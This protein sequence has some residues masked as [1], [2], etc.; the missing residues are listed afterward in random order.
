MSSKVFYSKYRPKQLAQ[1]V[2]QEHITGLLE[3]QFKACFF[4]HAYLLCGRYGCGKTTVARIIAKVMNCM[5]RAEGE[6]ATCG[7]CPSCIGIMNGTSTDVRELDGG[8]R[9]HKED[10]CEIVKASAYSPVHAKYRIFII[11]EFQE[12]SPHARTALLTE[13]EEPPETSVF[14]LT[15]TDYSKVPPQLASRCQRFFF[16]PVTEDRIATYLL[17][18]CEHRGVECDKEALRLIARISDGSLRTALCE[19]QSMEIAGGGAVKTADCTKYLGLMGR[20]VIYDLFAATGAKDAGQALNIVESIMDTAPNTEQIIAEMSRVLS[21]MMLVGCGS[22]V[23]PAVTPE[24]KGRI[25]VLAAQISPETMTRYS[26]ILGE[27]ALSLTVNINQRLVM[28]SIVV[29]MST[30]VS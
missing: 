25:E 27:A 1:V 30:S 22:S 2:G 9:G 16:K 3:A 23:A 15:T 8:S 14:I 13:L 24:E 7:E 6:T 4:H 19:L 12:L 10:M 29:S 17:K 11:N 18:L 26:K 20:E 28:E 5:N 21:A